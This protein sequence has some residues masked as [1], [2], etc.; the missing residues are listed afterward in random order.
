MNQVNARRLV[1]ALGGIAATSQLRLGGV[2]GHALERAVQSGE[3]HHVAR[4]WYA[5]ARIPRA[6]VTAVRSGGWVT[7]ESAMRLQGVWALDG[8]KVHVGLGRHGRARP[9]TGCVH[10]WSGVAPAGYPMDDVLTA[11][12]QF[13][14]CAPLVPI[15]ICADSIANRGLAREEE[16]LAVLQRTAIGRRAAELFDGSSQSGIETIARVAL[17]RRGVRLRSQVRIVGVGHVDLLIGDR[18]VL[19]LDGQEW[20]TGDDYEED[21]RRDL[22]L[23]AGGY[24]VVRVSYR[25]VTESWSS[26]ESEL[27]AIIR[28]G[29]HLW[30]ARRRAN[31]GNSSQSVSGR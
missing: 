10:H 21:R 8:D 28:R 20:H 13:T 2:S 19:E 3:L 7:C 25:Q 31:V 4:G 15:V 24:L 1:D 11:L 22:A 17:R 16:V 29:D 27:L 6:V 12:D 14:R 30:R 26:V 23:V 18:L 9:V 5:T